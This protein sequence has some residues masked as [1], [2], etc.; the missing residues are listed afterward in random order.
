MRECGARRRDYAVCAAET[1][2]NGRG[3]SF[4]SQPCVVAGRG[5]EAR[6][7]HPALKQSGI[8]L[9]EFFIADE[10]KA[11]FPGNAGGPVRFGCGH[12]RF[13]GECRAKGD[14]IAG[15]AQSL[16][17]MAAEGK[18][19]GSHRAEAERKN[20]FAPFFNSFVKNFVE[21]SRVEAQRAALMLVCPLC[22]FCEAARLDGQVF[23][24]V[25]RQR[26]PATKWVGKAIPR[27]KECF[28]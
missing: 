25:V 27:Q 8:K 24:R 4:S 17:W 21:Y 26:R 18:G 23:G 16:L 6:V 12:G 15:R 20:F 3:G 11:F 22:T 1:A 13:C 28:A 14:C 5:A 9:P 10:G 7:E 19:T 2:G